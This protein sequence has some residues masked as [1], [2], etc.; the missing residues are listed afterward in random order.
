MKFRVTY[1]EPKTESRFDAPR[2]RRIGQR[3]LRILGVIAAEFKSDPQSVQCFDLRTVAEAIAIVDERKRRDSGQFWP[4][5][6]RR[7]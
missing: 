2:P 6:G 1:N 4:L 3:A 7:R 5:P